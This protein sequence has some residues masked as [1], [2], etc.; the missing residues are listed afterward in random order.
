MLDHFVETELLLDRGLVEIAADTDKGLMR[1]VLDTG[2]T[3][4][5]LNEELQSDQALDVAVWDPAN[6]VEFTHLAIASTELG[7]VS[8]H[9]MPIQMPIHIE[10]IL[11]VEFF[12]RHAVFLDFLHSK[13]YI[14]KNS[15]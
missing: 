9:R 4:N 12:Q 14:S 8:F 15:E 11:G 3:W 6:V 2:A 10:G 13:A 7:S 5:V 1:L